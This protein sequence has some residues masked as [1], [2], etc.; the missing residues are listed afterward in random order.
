MKNRNSFD[1]T[2]RSIRAACIS[3]NL[4]Q[5]D[6]S[7]P[8]KSMAESALGGVSFGALLI[9]LLLLLLV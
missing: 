2:S 5:P 6:Y 8:K 1:R 9:G 7:F 4:P 3:R